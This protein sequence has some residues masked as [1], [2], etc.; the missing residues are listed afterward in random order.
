MSATER[1]IP[2][3]N[4]D[5]ELGLA[6]LLDPQRVSG[7]FQQA[8]AG[9]LLALSLWYSDGRPFCP[10]EQAAALPGGGG[11]AQALQ[12]PLRHEW[13]T[14]GFLRAVQGPAL[15]A[16]AVE[17]AAAC[18]RTVL[19]ALMA[20]RCRCLMTSALHG[21]VVEDAYLRLQEKADALAVSE[22][23]YRQLAARLEGEVRRQAE[24]IRAA[25]ARLMERAQLASVGQLAAGMAHEINNPL[26]FVIS[27]LGTL[28]QYGSEL[29]GLLTAARRLWRRLAASEGEGAD[30]DALRREAAAL[31][32]SARQQDLDYLLQDL[33]ELI[34]EAREGGERIRAIVANLKAFA[35]PGVH[36]PSALDINRCLE[37][38]LQV[39]APRMGGVV[40]VCRL[41]PLP[42]IRGSESQI[43]QVLMNVILNAV[44][45]SPPGG[46]IR[47]ATAVEDGRVVVVIGDEGP[48]IPP[49]LHSRIFEPFYTTREVG[50]GCGLGLT[51]AYN[52][53]QQHG[54]TIE[55]DRGPAPGATIVIRLPIHR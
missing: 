28:A 33:P 45:A 8:A 21:E 31:E 24:E 27:N 46:R 52:I 49:D 37:T 25:H 4:F 20:E 10:E 5:R 15:A 16:A 44:Q 11:E 18:I 6:D 17:G 34:R 55:V 50:D 7:I 32:D 1:F 26:G 12:L 23:R 2:R 47:I 30:G 14:V 13:E 29:G 43:H 41:A 9:G 36:T 19:E 39:L 42:A 40:P 48:G 38:T 3:D 54:G 35:Q 53:L 51:L 22:A